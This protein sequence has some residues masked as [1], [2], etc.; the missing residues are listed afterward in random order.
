MKYV[1]AF[2]HYIDQY[3]FVFILQ[4]QP[5]K[6]EC[7]S[8]QHYREHKGVKLSN[9]GP[10]NYS[11]R[12]RATSLAGNGSWTDPIA[13]YVNQIERKFTVIFIP[14]NFQKCKLHRN[15]LNY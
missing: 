5:E 1:Y 4:Q 11:A 10:G 15:L 12:V 2:M 3:V 6:H 9:L 13:F 7:V 8:R 14:I